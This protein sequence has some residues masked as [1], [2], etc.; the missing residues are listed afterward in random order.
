M[1]LAARKVLVLLV[2][3]TDASNV[4]HAVSATCDGSNATAAA[5]TFGFNTTAANVDDC[6]QDSSFGHLGLG[7]A[8]YPGTSL[9]VQRV[10][11]AD[12][13]TA[14]NYTSWGSKADAA[15]T[16]LGSYRLV[17][18][19]AYGVAVSAEALLAAGQIAAWGRYDFE[20]GSVPVDL[21]NVV[22]I[23]AGRNGSAGDGIS[24]AREGAALHY[25]LVH[26]RVSPDTINSHSTNR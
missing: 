11:I 1:P 18:S 25:L 17:A 8:L 7:G 5:I 22:M 9:D 6:Y 24:L 2:D 19:N 14:C 15:A 3:I 20:Q 13:V 12:T 4:T 10:H 21:T 26:K 16:N 23:S